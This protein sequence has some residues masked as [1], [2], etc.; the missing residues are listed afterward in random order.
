MSPLINLKSNIFRK[1]KFK[2][3]GAHSEGLPKLP[4]DILPKKPIKVTFKLNLNN[5]LKIKSQDTS[6]GSL[7]IFS[8]NLQMNK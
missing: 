8:V 5:T 7:S 4:S 6:K 1:V 3:I 2:F